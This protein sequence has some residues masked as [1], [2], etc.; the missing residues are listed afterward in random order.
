MSNIYALGW[1]TSPHAPGR[2]GAGPAGR[3]K[4]SFFRS[5]HQPTTS[6]QLANADTNHPTKTIKNTSKKLPTPRGRLR[7]ASKRP[8]RW[9]L[10]RVPGGALRTPRGVVV[11]IDQRRGWVSVLY[12]RSIAVPPT[13]AAL[14]GMNGPPTASSGAGGAPP[15][16]SLPAQVM[17]HGQRQP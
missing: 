5:H 3:I 10:S 17:L 13:A 12:E 11:I 1:T 6:T 9:V 16:C 15:P 2:G 7:G 14:S 4:S 8:T